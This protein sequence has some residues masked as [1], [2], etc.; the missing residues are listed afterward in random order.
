MKSFTPGLVMLAA[1]VAACAYG[2][3][4]PAKPV[5]LVV[6][7]TPGGGV[8]INARLLAPELTRQFGHQFIVDNRPGAGT[9][10]ANEY[11][12][13]ARASAHALSR[14]ALDRGRLTPLIIK[15][16]TAIDDRKRR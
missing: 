8:D 5:R 1:F 14:F 11:V 2:Q 13:K 10:I 4:Y 3:I 12:A 16:D 15:S 9:N 6:G 7:F